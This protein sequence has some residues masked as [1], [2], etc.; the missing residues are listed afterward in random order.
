M[1]IFGLVALNTSKIWMAPNVLRTGLVY[2]G[3]LAPE[4]LKQDAFD[5]LVPAESLLKAKTT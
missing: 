1:G 3:E 4:L 2:Q 5:Y